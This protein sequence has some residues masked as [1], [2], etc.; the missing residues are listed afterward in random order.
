LQ[1]GEHLARPLF[2]HEMAGALEYEARANIRREILRHRLVSGTKGQRTG[3]RQPGNG[4]FTAG[5]EPLTVLAGHIGAAVVVSRRGELTG[6]P[7]GC[8]VSRPSGGRE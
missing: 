5:E 6:P 3:N 2:R 4:E 7:N 8:D 1:C